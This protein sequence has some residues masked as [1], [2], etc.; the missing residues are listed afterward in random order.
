MRF[1]CIRNS[2]C[3][4]IRTISNCYSSVTQFRKALDIRDV[5]A[6]VLPFSRGVVWRSSIKRKRQIQVF[7]HPCCRE[8]RVG[9]HSS[10]TVYKIILQTY[11]LQ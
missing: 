5:V 11:N 6:I 10:N 2:Q 8:M 9:K 7:M 3:P 1:H 4:D